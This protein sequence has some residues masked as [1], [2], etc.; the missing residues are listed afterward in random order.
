[1]RKI[2]VSEWVTLD[3]IFDAETMEQWFAP[4]D[5]IGRQDYIKDCIHASD[6]ILIGRNTY[7]TLA[8]YWSAL[9]NN[10]MGIAEKLNSVPKFVVS[11]TLKKA[12]WNNTKII[13][14][15]IPAEVKKLK[16]LPGETIQIEGSASLVASLTDT[17]LIDEY[18]LLVHPIIQGSGK[19]FFKNEMNSKLQ[20]VATQSFDNGVILLCY[21]PLNK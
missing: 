2:I 11:T 5:S 17:G 12:D 9:K 8:P 18:R 1:M 19:R 13:R 14:E 3:G 10:E 20:L 15:D 21:K 6:A 4:F 7:E 16:E